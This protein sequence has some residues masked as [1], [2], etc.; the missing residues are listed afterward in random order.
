MKQFVALCLASCMLASSFMAPVM[1]EEGNNALVPYA[2]HLEEEIPQI[3]ISTED[4]IAIDDSS[5]ISPD[6]FKGMGG[7]LPAYDYVNAEIS[8][9]NCEGY[10][11]ENV[12]AKVKVRGNYTLNFGN[13]YTKVELQPKTNRYKSVN[14]LCL[15]P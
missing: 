9:S 12:S 4:G 8:V 6:E 10:A 11:L 7:V 3:Y 13:F 15:S 5:L 1:A 2:Y 14:A